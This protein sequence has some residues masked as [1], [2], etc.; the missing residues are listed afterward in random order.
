MVFFKEASEY[1]FIDRFLSIPNTKMI[2]YFWQ[3]NISPLFFS[4][5]FLSEE[6]ITFNAV[7][8]LL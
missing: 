5:E 4:I 2:T 3:K 8:R 6:K 7:T 1:V